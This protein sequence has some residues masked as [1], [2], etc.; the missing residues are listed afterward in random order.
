MDKNF[1]HQMSLSKSKCLHHRYQKAKID[2]LSFV[3]VPAT[4]AA[5]KLIIGFFSSFYLLQPFTVLM[6]KTCAIKQSIFL[7]CLWAQPFFINF[8]VSVINL[9]PS[10][11]TILKCFLIT[12]IH[13]H[14]ILFTI[15]EFCSS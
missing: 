9:N 3:Y 4:S 8:G 7:R 12:V 10:N 2:C 14:E 11:L 6:K 1:D 15:I 13:Y 5:H